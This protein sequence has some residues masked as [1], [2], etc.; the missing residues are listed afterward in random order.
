MEFFTKDDQDKAHL[1]N[2]LI[3]ASVALLSACLS[4]LGVNLQ[5][6]ALKA[7]REINLVAESRH[8]LIFIEDAMVS[9]TSLAEGGGTVPGAASYSVLGNLDSRLGL[10]M[11][12]EEDEFLFRESVS[13]GMAVTD[14][15][16]FAFM[17]S[18]PTPLPGQFEGN[19]M[20]VQGDTYESFSGGAIN[21]MPPAVAGTT[22]VSGP[23]SIAGSSPC[24][25]SDEMDSNEKLAISG[26]SQMAYKP[27]KN[28]VMIPKETSILRENHVDAV[29]TTSAD[30]STARPSAITPV[31]LA[32]PISRNKEM[33]IFEILVLLLQ[34]KPSPGKRMLTTRERSH[35][36]R[37]LYASTQWYLG[38][39]GIRVG[40]F[41]LFLFLMLFHIFTGFT[42]YLICQLFGSVVALGFISPVILAPLGS[43][44]LI[45]NIL[46]SSIFAGTRITRY[47]WAGTV[48]IVI[49]CAVVSTFGSSMPDS[50]QS[51]EDLIRLYSRPAFIAYFSVQLILVSCT[52]FLIKYLEF[53][54]FSM[55]SLI[56]RS[57]VSSLSA[58]NGASQLTSV[59]VP[60]PQLYQHT[61]PTRNQSET[62]PENEI[63]SA[64]R[65]LV[66]ST[67]MPELKRFEPIFSAEITPEL[68]SSQRRV[69]W[70]DSPQMDSIPIHP[71][72]TVSDSINDLDHFPTDTNVHQGDKSVSIFCGP[73]PRLST[74]VNSGVTNSELL[75]SSTLDPVVSTHQ[76]HFTP[77]GSISRRYGRSI[78]HMSSDETRPLLNGSIHRRNTLRD[79]VSMRSVTIKVKRGQLTSLV[80]VLYAIV[81]GI[82]ASETLLLTKSGQ[83]YSLN[84]ALHYCLPVLVIP[85]FYTLFTCLSLANSMVYLDAFGVYSTINLICLILGIAVI[86]M[87]VCVLGKGQDDSDCDNVVDDEHGHHR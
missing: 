16:D 86:V 24:L 21:L 74:N 4:S 76:D 57:S 2:F 10:Y 68:I 83:L 14:G 13:D 33:S 32:S 48:L 18:S 52:F 29:D 39:C 30:V 75:N 1:A 70:T 82:T 23:D 34:S 15:R 56:S 80:G 61:Q 69:G 84:K 17:R 60:S 26:I 35:L 77:V 73:S 28:S 64:S 87:G 42:L 65:E 78:S 47:D 6:L 20:V 7:Q 45:F 36:W 43:A 38:K 31:M 50:R 46:F 71:S 27:C 53:N 58:L 12:A 63:G 25:T 19:G 37:S 3:G 54:L 55:R 62:L 79:S 9:P 72:M 49:G 85:I 22:P 67:S 59:N 51:I 81:G 66:S 8:S 5:A 41:W 44:G 11:D 40:H